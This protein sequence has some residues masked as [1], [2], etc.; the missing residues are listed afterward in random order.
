MSN[1][2]KINMPGAFGGLMRYDEE[3]TSRFMLKPTHVIGFAV[4]IIV[5][6]MALR[7]FWPIAA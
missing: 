3:Y 4:A 1:D 6:V 7:I 2:N 5:F